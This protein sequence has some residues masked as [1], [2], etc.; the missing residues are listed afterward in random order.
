[1]ERRTLG[2]TE[3]LLPMHES[4]TVTTPSLLH[5]VLHDEMIRLMEFRS[6]E[7]LV[8]YIL[9]RKRLEG[10]EGTLT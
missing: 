4:E 1:M 3:F 6:R 9:L 8:V 5:G 10:I 7:I 2:R